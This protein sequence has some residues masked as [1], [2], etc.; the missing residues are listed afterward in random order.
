M[1]TVHSYKRFSD[2]QQEDGDS[3]RRQ[4]DGAVKFCEKHGYRLSDLSFWDKGKSA[5]SGSKQKLLQE[6]LRIM[7]ANDGRV[8]SGDI[9]LVEAVDRLSRK[10]IRQTQILVNSILIAGI[11]IAILFPTEKLYRANDDNDI[12]G[13]IEL[14]AFAFQ[15]HA[16]SKL[17]SD[18]LK[19]F[20]A[21]ERRRAYADKTPINSGPTPAWIERKNGVFHVIPESKETILY[22][23]RRMIEGAGGHTLCKELN[24][25]FKP[26]GK[27]R[28]WNE[29]YIRQLIIDR[30][31]L[32]DFQ[33]HTINDDGK[34]VPTADPPI[35]GYYP[36]L[37]DED[38]FLQASAARENR[39]I[40]RGPSG[41][42]VNLFTGTIIHAVD[43]CPMN[44]YTYQQRRADGRRVIFRRLKSQNAMDNLPDASTETVDLPAFEQ[45][46]LR[47]LR[48]LDTSI[49]NDGQSTATELRAA[50]FNI[51][52]KQARLAELQHKV[53][54][55]SQN[56][57]VLLP[58]MRTLDEDIHT[59]QTQVDHLKT[60]TL[61]LSAT[62]LDTL[63]LLADLDNTP[64]NRQKLREAIKRVVKRIII[65]P[66]KLGKMRRSPVGC[67][68]EIEFHS[69][70]RRSL[71][72]YRH[73]SIAYTD[74][75]PESPNLIDR[76]DLSTYK[77]S[78]K[79]ILAT[80][81]DAKET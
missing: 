37:T 5:F 65:L 72:Q 9:L 61:N 62:S 56:L 73:K 69:G 57:N 12:G 32:G 24:A 8:K 51:N 74:P 78:L 76:P 1:R 2:K 66:V 52:K 20:H 35:I 11:D 18:R 13:A 38:T 34:R 7:H 80:F 25:R 54:D 44:L 45:V 70:A 81:I 58:A 36:S 59:L 21:Q 33:P 77:K 47:H 55:D 16:Y 39:R 64:D 41:D 3:E 71:I 22:I 48:E 27:S 60:R 31:I 23:L 10:G 46:V 26:L 17:L 50:E 42:F 14:A 6:F 75:T 53:T 49:F 19:S 28:K 67:H 29:T 4:D 79:R 68:I 15:A 30:R 63:K 43:N 40:E